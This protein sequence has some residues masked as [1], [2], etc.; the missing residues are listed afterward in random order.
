MAEPKNYLLGYGERLTA[1]LDP[2]KRRPEKSDTYTFAE[3]KVRL[4]PRIGEVAAEIME[5]PAA[6]CPHNESIAAVTIHPSYLAKSYFPIGLFDTIGVRAVGSRPRQIL[7]EKGAKKL[8]KREN[9]VPSPTA[10][11]FVMGRRQNFQRWAQSVAGWSESFEG[12]GELVRVEDVH[13]IEP[14]ERIKPMRTGNDN[15][16]LEVVLHR[17]DDYV[18]EGFRGYLRELGV[19][20]DLNQRITVRELCFLPV[21]VPVEQHEAMARFSFLRVGERCPSCDNYGL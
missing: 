19:N 7:P 8:A 5:L 10:E 9:P 6:A 13:F 11:I 3:S 14:A 1:A 12:A 4:A 16:L 17:S 2:P 18:L 20:V 21:R 15:P